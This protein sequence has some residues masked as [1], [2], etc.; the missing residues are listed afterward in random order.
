NTKLTN[1]RIRASE[2][3]IGPDTQLE[4]CIIQ[5][6]GKVE[7]GK[8]VFI[9]ENAVLNAFKGISLGD[10]TKIDRK[11]I[12]GG[13]QSE[14]SEF[15]MGYDCMVSHHSYL[16]VTRE[17]HI[18]NRSGVGGFSCLFTHGSWQ[19]IFHGF[20]VKFGPIVFED[21]VYTGWNI[22]V[23]PDVRIG[24]GATIGAGAVVTKNVPAYALALGVPAKIIP[25][26]N[27]PISMDLN[28][29][30]KIAHDILDDFTNYVLGFSRLPV[31]RAEEKKEI[32][33]HLNNDFLM[34]A[35]SVR[36]DIIKRLPRKDGTVV[37]FKINDEIKQTLQ[38]KKIA[39]LEIDNLK[40][41]IRLSPL[42]EIYRS[43]LSR[44]G[45]KIH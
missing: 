9:R 41:S 36:A 43:F 28:E 30:D 27:L 12:V 17:I 29:K 5:S 10:H 40:R 33:L 21:D 4:P 3:I 42:G 39:W 19:N 24:K 38:K 22:F 13:M 26:P 34:Y 45:V 2:V 16:N 31:K 11:V 44:Y 25:R 23:M 7:L 37:S 1:A 32:W 20:P 8:G 15:V 14:R 18:G 6:S 35:P